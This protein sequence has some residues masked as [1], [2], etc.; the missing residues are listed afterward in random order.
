M[1]TYDDDCILSSIYNK[2]LCSLL[3][4][5][6]AMAGQTAEPNGLK[7]FLKIVFHKSNFL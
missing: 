2:A 5:M 3:V 1:D 4:H 6:L 7:V